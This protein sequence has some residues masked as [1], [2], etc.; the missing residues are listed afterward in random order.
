MIPGIQIVWERLAGLS[1]VALP[2][3]RQWGF[4]SENDHLHA[5]DRFAKLKGVLRF[6]VAGK[7][8]IKFTSIDKNDFN[9]VF[10]QLVIDNGQRQG[11]EIIRAARPGNAYDLFHFLL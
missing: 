5:F 2:P 8:K 10:A 4:G 3:K 7:R 1:N 11:C 6:G 9:I